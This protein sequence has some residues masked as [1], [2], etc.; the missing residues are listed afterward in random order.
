MQNQALHPT[1]ARVSSCKRR[2]L[3]R[4]PIRSGRPLP[5]AVAELYLLLEEHDRSVHKDSRKV[6][7]HVHNS[8]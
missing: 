3:F 8:Q 7:V 4:R 5:V 6:A 1:A 2:R